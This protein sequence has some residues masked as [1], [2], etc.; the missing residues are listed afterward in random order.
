MTETQLARIRA[1]MAHPRVGLGNDS[2]VWLNPRRTVH[3]ATLDGEYHG[4]PRCRTMM[5]AVR[6]AEALIRLI[7]GERI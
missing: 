6:K 5:G 7:E 4:H 1:I 3:G 2:P